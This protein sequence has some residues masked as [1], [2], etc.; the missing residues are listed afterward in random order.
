M[1]NGLLNADTLLGDLNWFSGRDLVLIISLVGHI[2]SGMLDREEGDDLLLTDK[3]GEGRDF[4][5]VKS[6]QI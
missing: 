2:F 1:S 6:N 4:C 5:N 3:A